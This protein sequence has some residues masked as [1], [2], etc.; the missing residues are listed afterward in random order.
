MSGKKTR[1]NGSNGL[2]VARRTVVAGAAWSVPA[3]MAAQSASAASVSCFPDGTTFR[4]QARGILLSGFL[5]GINLDN[6][7]ELQGQRA[8]APD[9]GSPVDLRTGAADVS[10]LNSINVNIGG[11]TRLLSSILSIVAPADAGV[12]NQYAQANINGQVRGASGAVTNGGAL[13]FDNPGA[14][15]F[16]DF[17]T[18]DLRTI[19]TGL[20]GSPAAGLV[21]QVTDLRLQIGA[22]IGRALL[23]SLC[24]PT[25]TTVVRD[26]QIGRLNLVAA[27]P[28]LGA[29]VTL[30][31]NVLTLVQNTVNAIPFNTIVIDSAAI[32][33]G[34][35]PGAGQPIQAQLGVTPATITI[36][37]LSLFGPAPGQ[38]G[39]V[40]F[41]TYAAYFNSLP[42]NSTLFVDNN[43]TLPTAAVTNFTTALVSTLT[44]RI[45]DNIVLNGTVLRNATGGVA[46]TVN[47]LL[48]TVL[49]GTLLTAVSSLQTLLLTPL[50]NALRDLIQIDVNAQNRST[51]P[52]G[53]AAFESLPVG[54]FDVAALYIRAVGAANLLDLFLA[55]GSGGENTPQP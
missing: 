19:L 25:A 31:S 49:N 39:N 41:G 29:I 10:A 30:V 24:V 21:G 20:A 28:L 27:S 23:D 44:A 42:P 17:A 3:I 48:N 22:L 4:A 12:L 11:T 51:N 7:V 2:G 38:P 52:T 14:A 35:I 40:P 9:Q 32:F 47:G 53:P 55:R 1:S 46:T 37:L 5:V 15:T 16:P 50:F 43:L 36:D 54:R 8:L 34:N 33:D 6:V 26:Y 13:V 45:Q 18:L